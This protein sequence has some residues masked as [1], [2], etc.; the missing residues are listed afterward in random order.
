VADELF[1]EAARFERLL[2]DERARSPGE[3]EDDAGA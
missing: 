1:D 3:G 2:S